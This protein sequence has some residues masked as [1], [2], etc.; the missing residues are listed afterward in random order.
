MFFYQEDLFI[1]LLEVSN[2]VRRH[3]LGSLARTILYVVNKYLDFW[4]RLAGALQPW[5]YGSMQL[6]CKTAIHEW[7]APRV[8]H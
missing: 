8:C 6:C 1:V 2:C 4:H 5:S 3:T 7:N